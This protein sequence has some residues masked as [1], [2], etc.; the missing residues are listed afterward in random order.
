MGVPE[1]PNG[2]RRS[3]SKLQRPDGKRSHSPSASARS[4]GGDRESNWLVIGPTASRGLTE[5]IDLG[6]VNIDLWV[7]AARDRRT[8]DRAPAQGFKL[9]GELALQPGEPIETTERGRNQRPK[10]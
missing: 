4:S 3:Q 10:N 1:H 9:L 2:A 5:T 8:G 6:T 7:L